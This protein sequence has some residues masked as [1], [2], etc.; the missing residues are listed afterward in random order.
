MTLLQ[1]AALKSREMKKTE[2]ELS[3]Q[4]AEYNILQGDWKA[5]KRQQNKHGIPKEKPQRI[6]TTVAS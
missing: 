4:K 2:K 3:K 1:S 6:K 5:N